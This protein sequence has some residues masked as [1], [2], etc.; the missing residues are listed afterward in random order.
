MFLEQALLQ[1]EILSGV[2]APRSLFEEILA[3]HRRQAGDLGA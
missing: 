1:F 3:S 2:G